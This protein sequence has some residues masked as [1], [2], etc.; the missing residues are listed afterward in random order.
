MFEPRSRIIP[1]WTQERARVTMPRDVQLFPRTGA[2][3]E[4][5]ATLSL[6]IIAMGRLVLFERPDSVDSRDRLRTRTDHRD[7]PKFQP[8]HSM[9]GHA[10]D[11][12]L[13]GVLPLARTARGDTRLGQGG[14]CF[15]RDR[16][17]AG[18]DR[19]VFAAHPGVRPGPNGVQQSS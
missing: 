4:E 12:L 15:L 11:L 6:Q 16:A 14:G 3:D 18:G 2:C 5:Q 7:A 9:D 17:G 10:L 1:G 13:D 19:D 8:L